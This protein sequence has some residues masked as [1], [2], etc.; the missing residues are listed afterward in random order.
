MR[1]W[2]LVFRV[3]GGECFRFSLLRVSGRD[4]LGFHCED[5]G[6]R[7]IRVSLLRVSVGE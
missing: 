4:S 6:W 3:S 2:G 1:G 7:V 5:F